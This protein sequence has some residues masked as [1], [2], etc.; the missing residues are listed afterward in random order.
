M[1]DAGADVD[2]CSSFESTY[3]GSFGLRLGGL[4][5]ILAVSPTLRTSQQ[6]QVQA[7]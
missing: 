5:I 2:A 7:Y 3:N 4:F 1:A 6:C